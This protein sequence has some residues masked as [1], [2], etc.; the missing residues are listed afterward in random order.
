MELP[1]VGFPLEVSHG[2]L[3][4]LVDILPCQD[5]YSAILILT[6][7]LPRALCVLVRGTRVL[8]V[9]LIH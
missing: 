3:L 7:P 8:C 4:C 9:S 2:G 5:M 6:F 1:S